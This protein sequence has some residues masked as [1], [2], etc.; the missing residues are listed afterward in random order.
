[1][2]RLWD[3][4][5]HKIGS[6][7]LASSRDDQSREDFYRISAETG[8]PLRG[9]LSVPIN[10]L[11][12]AATNTVADGRNDIDLHRIAALVR[13]EE[14]DR[15]VK[16]VSQPYSMQLCSVCQHFDYGAGPY[17]VR[18][19]A[20]LL[21]QTSVFESKC[22]LC[23][24]F[25][26]YIRH[27]VPGDVLEGLLHPDDGSRPMFLRWDVE[28]SAYRLWMN[29][30]NARDYPSDQ[31][32]KLVFS[33]RE[34]DLRPSPAFKWIITVPEQ[35][36]STDSED[37]SADPE[38]INKSFRF[39]TAEEAAHGRPDYDLICSWLRDCAIN[40]K[41]GTAANREGQDVELR[42]IDVI[43]RS[44]KSYRQPLPC[45]YA[46]SYVWGDVSRDTTYLDSSDAHVWTLATPLPKTFEDAMSITR[47]LDGRYL[48]I[49]ICCIDQH[50]PAK[51]LEQMQQMD[52]IF[53]QAALTIVSVS[54][55]DADSGLPGVSSD[56][57]TRQIFAC[58][59]QVGLAATRT[60]SERTLLEASP[61]NT[62]G[63]CLQEEVLSR[64]CLFFSDQKYWLRCQK[65]TY[66]S[67]HSDKA[68]LPDRAS[69][70]VR[71]KRSANTR[72]KYVSAVP[73]RAFCELVDNYNRRLLSHSS[74]VL[75]AFTGVINVFQTSAR[76]DCL[77]GL[78]MTHLCAALCWSRNQIAMELYGTRHPSHLQTRSDWPS[79]SWTGW[80]GSVDWGEIRGHCEFSFYGRHYWD[81][82]TGWGKADERQ[83][84]SDF[85]FHPA[86]VH[87][88]AAITYDVQESRTLHV[89]SLVGT[90]SF[91]CDTGQHD[92]MPI[93]CQLWHGG[94]LTDTEPWRAL[95]E[96]RSFKLVQRKDWLYTG[97]E[98]TVFHVRAEDLH[99]CRRVGPNGKRKTTGTGTFEGEFLLL[100][101]LRS[102]GPR[103][104]KPQDLTKEV[105]RRRGVD[106]DRGFH[107]DAMVWALLIVRNGDGT[108][109]RAALVRMQVEVWEQAGARQE[110]VVLV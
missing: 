55:H 61:W 3:R 45:Y 104:L 56:C 74:D 98:P 9:L 50:D 60:T 107:E 30:H 17:P 51:K 87:T 37:P 39:M 57:E 62:R 64:R 11:R 42:L 16:Q 12:R 7:T 84:T 68:P 52:V 48:W 73:T 65:S 99:S 110:D 59:A 28:R 89:S 41:C 88:M 70:S 93:R 4:A 47:H 21:D 53:S 35:I 18:C 22:D 109:R 43:Q 82:A 8:S 80:P 85:E 81:N 86:F 2:K 20:Q 34:R 101:S 71:L 90:L 44:V 108:A 1:M 91:T 31:W 77:V 94:D 10:R 78:P 76:E 79:W 49:D 97:L 14:G 103:Q 75:A 46:L 15:T 26:E 95:R 54:G 40:H 27:S 19:L 102:M 32:T 63:W 36:V 5:V 23:V 83:Q 24:F 106:E 38:D 33:P 100:L 25:A 29:W 58:Q 67:L 66:T 96:L 69:W 92:N 105:Y 72:K 6:E 13:R